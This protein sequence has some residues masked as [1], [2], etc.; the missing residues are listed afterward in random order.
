MYI[1]RFVGDFVL[2]GMVGISLSS[3]VGN[4]EVVSCTGEF[5]ECYDYG[6]FAHLDTYEAL[7]SCTRI[8]WRSS[9]SKRLEDCFTIAPDVHW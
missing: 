9:Q 6:D 3:A 5:T 4:A 1:S 8:E 7:D 2:N